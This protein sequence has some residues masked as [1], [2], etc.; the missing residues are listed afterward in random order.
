MARRDDILLHASYWSMWTDFRVTADELIYFF[1]KAG[2]EQAPSQSEAN[3][4]LGRSTGAYVGGQV[5]HWCGIFACAV[6]REAGLNVRWTLLGGKIR[7]ESNGTY[8]KYTSGRWGI[9]P[10]D[11]ALIADANHHFLITDVDSA[12]KRYT[13]LEGNTSGQMVRTRTRPFT[14]WDSGQMIYGYYKILG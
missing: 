11:I 10:G 1:K 12:A 7:N 6:L 13:T 2:C 5:K 3:K 14:T 4:S 9:A 8:V